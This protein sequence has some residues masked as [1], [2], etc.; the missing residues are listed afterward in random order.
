MKHINLKDYVELLTTTYDDFNRPRF[1]HFQKLRSGNG[2][3]LSTSEIQL[4]NDD[5]D[6]K[7]TTLIDSVKEYISKHAT[8]DNIYIGNDENNNLNILEYHANHIA[9]ESK[10]GK[11][12]F[13]ID[14][15]FIAYIGT[16][17][18]DNGLR[19]LEKDGMYAIV[20]IDVLSGGNISSLKQYYRILSR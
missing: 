10:R 12:N 17:I 16:N 2:I 5:F 20:P 1:L 3:S 7:P 18:N 6:I 13:V 9:K 15:E 19:I 8:D 14:N 4:T 11:G